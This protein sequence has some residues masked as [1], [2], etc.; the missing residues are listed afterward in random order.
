MKVVRIV[1][2]A[3]APLAGQAKTRLIPALGLDGSAALAKRLLLYTVEQA[4]AA[5]IGPVELCVT[6][7]MDH[8]IWHE[9]EL[10]AAVSWSEQG[11]GDLGERLSRAS[12]RVSG[13][14]ES[15]LLIGTDCPQLDIHR[16]Q[17]AA[18]ALN[19]HD[20]CLLP[21]SDGGYALLG[22]RR[23]HYSLFAEIPWSTSKVAH[24]TCQRITAIGWS[25]KKFHHLH[26][27]DEPEDLQRLPNDW[28]ILKNPIFV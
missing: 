2:F 16:L 10:S 1:I 4:V 7:S 23:H 3:K 22:L 28:E 15:M 26:D 19:N 13:T 12:Q 8:P 11:G 5:N 21:V 18:Q 14:G 9:L 25:M 20:T 27:I 24:L 6:P 17:A